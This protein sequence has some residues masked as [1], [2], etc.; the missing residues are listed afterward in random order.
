MFCKSYYAFCC[1]EI[2]VKT[3]QQKRS[4]YR[5]KKKARAYFAVILTVY[6]LLKYIDI[7]HKRKYNMM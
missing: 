3:L 7:V 2:F 1:V 5:E 6:I 4:I